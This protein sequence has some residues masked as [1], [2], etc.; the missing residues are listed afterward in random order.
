M[1][2]QL[3]EL[4]ETER[5]EARHATAVS[6][7][8]TYGSNTVHCLTE[9]SQRFPLAHKETVFFGIPTRCASGLSYSVMKKCCHYFAQ[10]TCATRCDHPRLRIITLSTVGG[11]GGFFSIYKKKR[12]SQGALLSITPFHNFRV[13]N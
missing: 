3:D 10:A 8:Q 11:G 12:G 1:G 6:S 13:I 2:G 9:R 4:R 7:G 5:K